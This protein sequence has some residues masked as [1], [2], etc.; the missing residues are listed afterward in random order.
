MI[1]FTKNVIKKVWYDREKCFLFNI[2]INECI[3]FPIQHGHMR[4]IKASIGKVFMIYTN[5]Q[6]VNIWMW[7][8]T[9]RISYFFLIVLTDFH[10]GQES[11]SCKVCPQTTASSPCL[12][13]HSTIHLCFAIHII[14]TTRSCLL[15]SYEDGEC[16]ARVLAFCF[17][18]G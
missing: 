7:F 9:C 3:Q 18:F 17:F 12:V 5:G 1:L 14:S 10:S 13:L 8:K 11:S 6:T 4:M 16:Y 2:I 15:G